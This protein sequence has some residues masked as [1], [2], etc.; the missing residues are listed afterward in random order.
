MIKAIKLGNKSLEVPIIQGG[1]GV[2]IS[3]GRLAGNVAKEGGMGV[4]SA[5]HPGYQEEDFFTHTKEANLRALK[6]EIEKAKTISS[7]HGLIG[8]NIMVAGENYEDFVKASIEAKADVII[9]GAGLPLDLPRYTQGSSILLAPIVSSGKALKLIARRWDT[10]Y[11][12]MMD[13]VVIEG[14]LAGG[15]LGFKKDDLYHETYQSNE[16]ILSDV[17]GVLREYEEKYQKKIPVFVA[18]GVYTHEDIVH[19][20]NL[21]ASGVQ[22]GTRFIATYECDASEEFKKAVVKCKKE[23]I[24]YIKSPTGLI[25]RALKNEFILGMD[26]NQS[27][28]VPH[29]L[30]CLKPCNPNATCYC[31]S[32]ALI[33]SAKGLVNQGVVFVGANA[34]RI[35]EIVTVKQLM[36]EL[37]G[38]KR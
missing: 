29:C 22:I 4:I 16:E 31:I 5:A 36:D 7:H 37:K 34:Y 8:V 3:L 26:E 6:N 9:S 10:H 30:H 24:S 11:Q 18:G 15:H 25:G 38:E 12:R 23:D 19:F 27:I 13:F 35:K 21:G 17:L 2:G 28:S 1:M 20:I 33:R 14:A 32:M